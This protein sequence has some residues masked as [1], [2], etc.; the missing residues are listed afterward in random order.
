MLFMKFASGKSCA[1]ESPG[2]TVT[3]KAASMLKIFGLPGS[4]ALCSVKS[5]ET[6][7]TCS[8]EA[9]FP[10]SYKMP[11]ETQ[12]SSKLSMMPLS[13]VFDEGIPLKDAVPPATS[14]ANLFETYSPSGTPPFSRIRNARRIKEIRVYPS[15]GTAASVSRSNCAYNKSEFLPKCAHEATQRYTD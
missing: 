14:E 11:K 15:R 1:R 8:P 9:F 2:I 6:A 3:E 13:P 5:G 10:V 12:A 4:G 7:S